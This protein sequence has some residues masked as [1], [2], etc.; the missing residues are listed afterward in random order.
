MAKKR[1]GKKKPV[2]QYKHKGKKRANNPPVGLVTPKTDP[3]TGA[4]TKY[5]YDPQLARQTS[6]MVINSLKRSTMEGKAAAVD[7]CV[8]TKTNRLTV[9]ADKLAKK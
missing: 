5:A 6:L 3:D 1:A 9:V 7:L 4:K 8:H 2:E